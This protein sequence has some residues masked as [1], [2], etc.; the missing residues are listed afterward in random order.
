MDDILNG[1]Y[2]THNSRAVQAIF[3]VA[4]DIQETYGPEG[5]MLFEKWLDSIPAGE[6]FDLDSNPEK[7]AE[8]L[9]SDWEKFAEL[10]L[11]GRIMARALVDE[12][13]KLD[14]VQD[15]VYNSV[16]NSFLEAHK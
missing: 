8:D 12:L 9:G 15:Y 16:L 2:Q 14:R 3:K 1:V 10:D 4:S 11:Q 13:G 5:L 6:I 7:V